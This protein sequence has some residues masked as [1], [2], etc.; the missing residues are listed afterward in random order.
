M[1]LLIS[2][3]K[4]AAAAGS[5]HQF[6]PIVR[7]VFRVNPEDQVVE[8]ATVF[9]YSR[10]AHD[11][12]GTRFALRLQER[13]RARYKTGSA[14]EIEK[15]LHRIACRFEEHRRISSIKT[16]L[17]CP[18][19]EFTEHVR[20]VIRSLLAEAGLPDDPDFVRDAFP[21]FEAAVQRLKAHLEGIKR[22]NQYLMG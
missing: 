21:R 4:L 14:V 10:V 13:L 9:L 19:S 7:S 15:M 5:M 1:A 8:A 22:Q 2:K 6:C 3:R 16:P 17:N 12:F 20:S 11:V 18:H